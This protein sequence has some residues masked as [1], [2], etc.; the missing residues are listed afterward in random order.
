MRTNRVLKSTKNFFYKIRFSLFWQLKE[1]E[2]TKLQIS[3]ERQEQQAKS[4]EEDLTAAVSEKVLSRNHGLKDSLT[5]STLFSI[6]CLH[7]V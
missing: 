5:L 4:R 2:I 6:P 7:V 3:L 1:E